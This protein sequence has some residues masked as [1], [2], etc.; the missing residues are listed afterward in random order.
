MSSRPKD[1]PP[2]YNH[3]NEYYGPPEIYDGEPPQPAYSYYPDDEFQHFYRWSSPPGIIKIVSVIIVILCVAIFA[4]VASTLA[5][6]T[7]MGLMGFGGLGTGYGGAS[8]GSGYSS[9]GGAAYGPGN[10]YGYG[11]LGGNYIDPRKGKGFIIAMG[12][13]CF[14]AMLV[15]FILIVSRQNTAKTRKFYLAVIIICAILAFF[16]FIA[17]IVYLM[18]VNPMAQSSGSVF[19]NQIVGLCAQYQNPQPSSML[20][21]QYLY[22]YCV[23]EPQEAIAI[24][25]GFL[26]TAGLIIILVFALKTRQ[27]I[28]RNGKEQILWSKVKVMDEVEAPQDV[29]EWVNNVSAAPGLQLN[30]YPEKFGGSRSHLD[31]VDMRHFYSPEAPETDA[32]PRGA[33]PD[34]S[35]SEIASSVAKPPKR[36]PARPPRVGGYETAESGDE[37]EED[38]FENE[39]PPIRDEEE[40]QDY[41]REFDREHHEYKSLQAEMDEVNG[42]LSE[43]DRRLDDLEEDSPEFLVGS[44]RASRFLPRIFK[45][46]SAALALSLRRMFSALL[47][48]FIFARSPPA[49]FLRDAFNELLG[50]LRNRSKRRRGWRRSDAALLSL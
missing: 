24:V 1:S 6:D 16:M 47:R 27:K 25:F 43:L 38:D 42:K 36:R 49:F 3:D 18:A 20:V 39:F 14:I 21:N 44:A 28:E 41:K 50:G 17:T 4:C 31:D 33:A 45:K 46:S 13:I 32:P 26:V 37:L 9:F 30:E 15:I 5:W 8:Y 2:P 48:F 23:V 19:Q 7:D 40:R 11:T 34:S 22:H 29:E 12:G 10:A 35:G